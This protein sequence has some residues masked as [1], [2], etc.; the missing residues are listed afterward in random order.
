MYLIVVIIVVFSFY[1]AVS[2]FHSNGIADNNY[3]TDIA[4]AIVFGIFTL[5]IYFC[6]CC[7]Y[8]CMH[9]I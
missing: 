3:K 4:L 9:V 8:L 1:I 2:E 7:F 6:I 5:I